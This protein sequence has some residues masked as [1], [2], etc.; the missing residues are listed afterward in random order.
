[1]YNTIKKEFQYYHNSSNNFLFEKAFT[2]SNNKEV[3]EFHQKIAAID[4]VNNYYLRRPNCSWVFAGLEV[5]VYKLQNTP[6]GAPPT[7]LDYINNSKAI[8]GL[9]WDETNRHEFDDHKCIF[10][11]LALYQGSSIRSLEQKTDQLKQEFER[12]AN[13]SFDDGIEMVHLPALEDVGGGGWW[14]WWWL[15]W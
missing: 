14:W 8:I 4:L 2:I 5:Y 12:Y 13:I 6:I 15:W 1:M 11:C 3:G 10:R 9:T 7:L